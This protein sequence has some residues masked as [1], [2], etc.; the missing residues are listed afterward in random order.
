VSLPATTFEIGFPDPGAELGRLALVRAAAA[1]TEELASLASQAEQWR[2]ALLRTSSDLVSL[3]DACTRDG[4]REGERSLASGAAAVDALAG[5]LRGGFQADWLLTGAVGAAA[6][7]RIVRGAELPARSG[8]SVRT[9]IAARPAASEDGSCGD[10]WRDWGA[11]IRVADRAGGPPRDLII[12]DRRPVAVAWRCADNR[13]R[14]ETVTEPTVVVTLRTLWDLLW[15][16]ALPVQAADRLEKLSGDPVKR[17]ILE[18]LN[19]GAKDEVIARSLDISL[20]TCRRH[21]AEILAAAGATSRFQ[22]AA[23]LARAGL[24]HQLRKSS[25]GSV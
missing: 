10:L 17:V 18:Q 12:V 23:R 22:A 9:L 21:I 3:A 19:A 14:V 6:L 24:L 15:A 5:L 11:E 8:T 7:D 1:V 25:A 2:H 13:L 4:S 20:R 16:Q